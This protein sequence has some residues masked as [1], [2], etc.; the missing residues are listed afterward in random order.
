[1]SFVLDE[2]YT[3]TSHQSPLKKFEFEFAL[4]L[5]VLCEI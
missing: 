2:C 5:S 1:V 4:L 3:L